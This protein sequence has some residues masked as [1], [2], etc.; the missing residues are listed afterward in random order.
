MTIARSLL[1]VAILM[2]CPPDT[3]APTEAAG[4]G[5]NR[6][7]LDVCRKLKKPD[8]RAR[9]YGSANERIGACCNDKPLPPLIT[10]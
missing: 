8:V 1:S 3:P 9:C 6:T 4:S 7:D 10:R 2:L 5:L